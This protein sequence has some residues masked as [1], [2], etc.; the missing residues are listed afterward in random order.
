[1]PLLGQVHVVAAVLAL[2]SGA[3]VLRRPK[4]TAPHR[5][6]GWVYVGAMLLTNLTA[7][8]IYRLF[9]RFGPFHAAALASLVTTLLGIAATRLRT[10][11]SNWVTHHY[12]WMTYSYVGLVAAAVAETTTRTLRPQ[13]GAAFG[14]AVLVASLAVFAVGARSVRRGAAAQLAPFGGGGTVS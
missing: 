12:F 13:S 14:V 2:A 5:A 1:M 11:R 8:G 10:R 6:L 4:G 7:L 9:G 3:L